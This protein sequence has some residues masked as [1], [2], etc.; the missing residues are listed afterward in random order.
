MAAPLRWA[1]TLSRLVIMGEDSVPCGKA[2]GRFRF[3]REPSFKGQWSF[4][5]GAG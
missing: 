3:P 4:P 1:K 5:L 2:P